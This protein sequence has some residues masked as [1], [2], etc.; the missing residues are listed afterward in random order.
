MDASKRAEEIAHGRPHPFS[1]IGMNFANTIAIVISGPFFVGV[2]NG[3][4]GTDNMIVALP[5][6][7][8]DLSSA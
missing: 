4:V 3:G 1:R 8:V 6:I 7:S 5:F 2:T